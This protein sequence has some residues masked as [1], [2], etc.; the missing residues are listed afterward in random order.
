MTSSR[1]V[2]QQVSRATL[3]VNPETDEWVTIQEGMLVFVTF[4]NPPHPIPPNEVVEKLGSFVF[5]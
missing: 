5:E 4:L 3:Q 1:V 2:V